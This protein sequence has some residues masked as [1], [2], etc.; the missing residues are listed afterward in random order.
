MDEKIYYVCKYTPLELL[1]GFGLES[2]RL[3]PTPV[4]FECADGCTHPNLCGYGKAVIEEVTRRGIKRLLLVDCCDVC[5]RVFDVLSQR[6]DME[7]LFLMALP[8]KNG[9]AEVRL[10]GAEFIR[11]RC[12]LVNLTG[13]HFDM[14]SALR[15]W[16]EGGEE[17]RRQEISEQHI[18]LTGAHGGTLLLNTI[19]AH[20]PLPVLD[21]T[22]TG[23]RELP[24][25]GEHTGTFSADY[26]AAILNQ[27]RACMR[28]QFR[29]EA[30][31]TNAVGVICH[32]VKFC[33]YYGFQY[34]HLKSERGVPLLKIETDC[35]AQSSGQLRTRIDAFSE[36]LRPKSAPIIHSG[37]RYFAGV[38]SGS[39]STDA[40][41]LD[42]ERRIIGSAILPTGAGAA[43]G[44]EKALKAALEQAGLTRDDLAAVVTTGYGR[45]TVGLSD[46]S[47]T[48]ITCHAKGAHFL[49]PNTRTVIDIGGQDSKVIRLDAEGNVVNF[50]MNDKCAAGTGRFL[51]MMAR[52]LQ[53]SLKDMSELGLE[54]KNEVAISSM[55]TVFAESEVVSLIAENTPP[56]DIVRGLNMAVATKTSAL[57][58]R[59]GSEPDYV[60]TG[61]VAQNHGVVRALEEKL[62]E[63]I[64]VPEEAQLCGA[65]GA[66]LF[67]LGK[68]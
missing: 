67:A 2:E 15:A 16:R 57:V 62:G 64:H 33:D 25:P 23:R 40:V 52:T 28:M 56:A 1:A 41:I 45:E 14:Q 31:D 61:G 29:K 8:H 46:A 63:T 27:R 6:G 60:M 59:L 38:D 37:G 50:V 4:S 35:T 47:V 44:A 20:S 26:A 5:R 32:T 11:L 54:W 24:S 22:C 19:R 39:A 21:D 51:E 3:D 42:A 49:Y 34:H 7:F 58:R 65:L 10:L 36:T 12:E 53:L 43:S 18:R 17:V 9:S 30:E 55:C 13:R 68:N 66:A 48:E